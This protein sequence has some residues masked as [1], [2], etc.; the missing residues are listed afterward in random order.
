MFGHLVFLVTG[1]VCKSRKH[2]CL[3]S[4]VGKRRILK[5]EMHDE[6]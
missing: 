5:L 6:E 3:L 4:E 2:T 1:V